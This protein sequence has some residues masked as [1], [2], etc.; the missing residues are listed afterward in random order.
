MS[1]PHIELGREEMGQ[2]QEP[3]PFAEAEKEPAEYEEER[4]GLREREQQ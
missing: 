2:D 4:P 3:D 1:N